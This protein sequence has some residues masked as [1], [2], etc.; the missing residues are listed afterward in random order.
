M[1]AP[2]SPA[3]EVREPAAETR[4]LRPA[5]LAVENAAEMV[6]L[7][8]RTGGS[9]GG[10]RPFDERWPYRGA[11]RV[12]LVVGEPQPGEEPSRAGGGADG[13]RR[14]AVEHQL[15]A[16]ERGEGPGAVHGA[17]AQVDEPPAG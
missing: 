8:P 12:T 11:Q 13:V 5:R 4:P 17:P 10:G 1:S 7:V 2:W 14:D 9:G 6:D 3:A 16:P 15:G